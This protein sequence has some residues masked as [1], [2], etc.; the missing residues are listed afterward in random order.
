MIPQSM[1][2]TDATVPARITVTEKTSGIHHETTTDSQ[3][4]Y[5]LYDLP[6]GKYWLRCE[7][8]GLDSGSGQ[9]VIVKPPDVTCGAFVCRRPAK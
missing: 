9:E 6:Q 7:A 8:A 2:P 3:G 1:L 4:V 5:H